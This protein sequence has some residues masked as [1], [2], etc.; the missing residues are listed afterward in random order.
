MGQTT[1]KQ[2]SRDFVALAFLPANAMPKRCATV[3]KPVLGA[4]V[5]VASSLIPTATQAQ[6]RPTALAATQASASELRALDQQIDRLVRS[7]D[8][9]VR[10]E[11]RDP[12]LPARRHERLDQYHKGVRI[13]GGDL[14]RQIAPDGTVSVLGMFHQ[15]LELETTASLS[16]NEARAAIANAAGGQPFGDVELVVL[17]LSD[18]YHLAYY[19]QAFDG[20]EIINVFV[21]ADSGQPIRQYSDFVTEIGKGK[22]TYGDDKKVSAKTL[23]GTFLA[24]DP[25]RPSAITTYDM[26]GDFIRTTNVLNRVVNVATSDIAS[27]VDNDWADST[28][29]DAHVHAGWYYDFLFKRFGRRGLDDR[30]LRMAVITHPVRLA[31]ISTAPPNVRGLF[32]INAFFC[33]TC[34]PDGRG[35]IML[36]EG[37]PRGFLAPNLEV[38]PFAAAL[39]VVAHELTHAVTAQT[40]R[41]NGFPFSEAGALNEGF[42]DIFGIATSFFYQ[43]AGTGP[44]NANYMSGNAL[45]VPAGAIGRSLADPLSTRYPDHFT[46]RIIGGDPHFNGL[47]PGHAFF[48]AIEGGRNR[49]SGLTVQGVGAANREQIDKSFFRALTLLMPSGSTFALTRAATIQAARDLY[50]AG[51]AAERAITQAWDAVGVQERTVPTAAVNPNPTFGQNASCGVPPVPNWIIGATASAGSSN[52]RVTQWQL[53][54]FDASGVSL[55]TSTLSPASFSSAFISCGPGSDRLVANADACSVLCVGLGGRTSGSIQFSFTAVDDAGR[56]QTAT[57]ARVPLAAPR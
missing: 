51:S 30:N 25:L 56:T 10:E 45:T 19:G 1:A 4:C 23:A 3:L 28:V 44:L 8:L 7:G 37:A 31:D 18:G 9:R 27:D 55:L 6:G 50:G 16:A 34:G 29:V 15:G 42:S 14:T 47:I 32:Y 53:S 26:R 49:T 36:G 40:S 20:V 43:P 24:D 5:M 13:V 35:V 52:L 41:L 46:G 11:M 17:P 54:Y 39:D 48:L 38:K 22:G 12:L 2:A 21:D 33:S 57:S